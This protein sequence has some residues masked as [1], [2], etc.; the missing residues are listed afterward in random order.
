MNLIKN[1][2]KCLSSRK[3]ISLLL[4]L[5]FITGMLSGCASTKNL[6]NYKTDKEIFNAALS[7]QIDDRLDDAEASYKSLMEKFPLSTYTV[8]AQ[9]KLADLY[10][11][12]EDYE[13]AGAYYTTFVAIHPEHPDAA[14]AL[15]QKGMSLFE[16][17]LSADR[18][19]TSTRKALFAFQD[20][21]AGYKGSAYYEKAAKLISFLRHRLAE[22]ELYIA[23]FYYKNKKYKGALSRYRDILKQYSDVGLT[24]E[25]L[26]FIGES[27]RKLGEHDMAR[28]SYDSLIKE[29]SSSSY[30]AKARNIIES[31]KPDED[32]E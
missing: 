28:Q 19:Q 3:T 21:R 11:S 14:Y 32:E 26:F 25:V 2:F 8:K 17:V 16:G 13:L 6:Q 12:R 15:F 23:G 27:Y 24:P 7:S 1:Y 29:Y 5:F 4:A 9:L 30:A 22:R 10:Y 18:D 31:L 20:L